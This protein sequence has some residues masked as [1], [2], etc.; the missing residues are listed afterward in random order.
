ME[1]GSHQLSG[2]VRVFAEGREIYGVY[3]YDMDEGWLALNSYSDEETTDVIN[4]SP[5]RKV[6]LP[7]DVVIDWE[8]DEAATT[9]ALSSTAKRSVVDRIRSALKW[10]KLI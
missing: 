9:E 4:G 7:F 2:F 1:A 8:A 10:G 5:V 6:F 3:A